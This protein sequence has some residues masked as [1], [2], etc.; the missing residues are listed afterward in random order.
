MGVA[1]S[2]TCPGADVPRPLHPVK[3]KNKLTTLQDI[4]ARFAS[5]EASSARTS[6]LSLLALLSAIIP[7]LA[8]GATGGP[9]PPCAA[10]AAAA[11]PPPGA[12]PRVEV[13]HGG[14]LEQSRW[15]P[16]ECS[17]WAPSSRSKL[18]V[19]MAGSFRFDGTADELL[20]RIG[21]ISTLRSIRYWSVLNKTWRPLV[22]DSSALSRPDP[23]SRRPDFMARE[24]TAG[25]ELYYY[26]N[27]S[28][29]GQTV[30]RMTVRERSPTRA[31][32]AVENL[33]PLRILF[34]TL[35]EPGALQSVEFVELVSPGVWG[36]YFL[37]R[38]RAGVSALAAG[39][40]APYINRAVALYRHLIGMPTDAD[41]PAAR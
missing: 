2:N 37:T 14:D 39:W 4:R 35:F 5:I 15:T 30:Y 12:P 41:P 20:A 29:S 25:S 26:G 34:L 38:T 10:T 32:I 21:A 36:V 17:G 9:Q 8:S 3:M 13:W 22:I 24:M 28:R 6:K 16:P 40:D 27:D 1:H 7:A 33:S 31:V 23:G 19:A 18:V 11:Y